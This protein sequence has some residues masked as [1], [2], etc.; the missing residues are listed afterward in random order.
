MRFT[1]AALMLWTGLAFAASTLNDL[2]EAVHAND[3]GEVRSLLDAGMDPN[4]TD[5]EGYSLL[6]LAA[7]EGHISIVRLLL[8]HKVKVDQQNPV[9]E[10]AVMLAAFKGHL[11]TVK[12]IHARGAVLRQ[13]GWTA[14]HYAAFQGHAAIARYLIDS[15]ADVNARAPNGATPLMLA[16][17]NGHRDVVQVLL[18]TA[19]PNLT[20]DTG[21]TA[22]QWALREGHTEI[23]QALRR[24]G[25]RQ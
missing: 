22:L 14:L 13:S 10:T 3:V 8:N 18:G 6:M 7:R 17:R 19:D 4:S 12:L 25:A 9:G 1:V 21:A 24:S 5:R 23:A 16:A 20:T 11:E 2:F 15:K